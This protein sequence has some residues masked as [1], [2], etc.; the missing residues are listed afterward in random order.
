L[1]TNSFDVEPSKI[2]NYK[3]YGKPEWGYNNRPAIAGTFKSDEGTSGRSL[4]L[5][6]H[7]DVVDAGPYSHWDTDPYTP[8]IRNGNMYGRCILDMKGGL[9]ANIFALQAV[10]KAGIKLNGDIQIQTVIEEEVTGN[11]ALALLD[12]GYTADGAIIPEP[13]Q[14][15]ILT[16]QVGV[17][18][19]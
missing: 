12:A 18:Y 1:E 13:T 9:A 14:H 4:I 7:I 10:E 8:T 16:S 6:S 3:N 2:S 19:M 15:R 11:G 5:Q 17:M